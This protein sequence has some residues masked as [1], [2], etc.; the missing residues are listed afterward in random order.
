MVYIKELRIRTGR[1]SCDIVTSQVEKA[2]QESGVLNGIAVIESAD[3]GVGILKIAGCTPEII[4]DINREMRRLVPARINFTNQDSPENTAGRIKEA[5]YGSSV[6]LIV[7]N[8]K[9]LCD[10]KQDVCFT[11]YDGPQDRT[12]TICVYGD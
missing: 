5:F 3:A 12:F 11:D 10:G 7:K 2:I 1:D 6:S 8:G 4:E 9:L